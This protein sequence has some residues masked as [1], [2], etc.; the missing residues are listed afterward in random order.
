MQVLFNN[1]KK[2]D[3]I[4]PIRKLAEY[5]KDLPVTYYYDLL[6]KYK[7]IKIIKKEHEDILLNYLECRENAKILITFSNYNITQFKSKLKKKTNF[8]Y[9]KSI[10]MDSKEIYALLYQ[11]L[12]DK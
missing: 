4:E 2:D 3:Y 10:S 5:Y 1:I 11:L 7:N 9:Y 8:Y 6:K 12:Y